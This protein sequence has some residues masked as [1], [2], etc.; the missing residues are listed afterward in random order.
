MKAAQDWQ[1]SYADL[2]RRDN[3]FAVGDKV[4]FKVSPM[5]GIIRF[6]KRGKLS[7]KYIGPYKIFAR[8]GEVAYRL[9][10][11]PSL[12]QVH[13]VFDVSQLWKYM[14]DPS[15]V[16]DVEKIELDEALTY[17]EIPK[18]VLDRKVSKTRNGESVLL[19]VLWSNHNVEEATWKSEEA[20]RERYPDHFE[21]IC[22][23]TGS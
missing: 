1:K 17:A 20:V 9:A 19:K 7:K 16:L 10:L 14:S 6:D 4:L 23:V 8:V 3:K 11:P 13:N 5:R 15:H 18:E 2:H 12:D 21:Q 22:L